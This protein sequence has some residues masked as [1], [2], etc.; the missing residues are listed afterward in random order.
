MN[1]LKDQTVGGVPSL[2]PWIKTSR[3]YQGSNGN[4]A[5]QVALPPLAAGASALPR[6][7]L[8]MRPPIW[9]CSCDTEGTHDE[10]SER[11]FLE[12]PAVHNLEPPLLGRGWEWPGRVGSEA[13]CL[14]RNSCHVQQLDTAA[15]PADRGAEQLKAPGIRALI[16]S[17]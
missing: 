3:R 9:R 5:P 4:S 11:M 1:A 17:A 16:F 10:F 15:A 13:A 8:A 14:S 6:G 12:F 7:T 2:T